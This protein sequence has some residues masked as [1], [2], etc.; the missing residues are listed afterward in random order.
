MRELDVL[1]MR[2]LE[3][4]FQLASASERAAF[5]QLL[6]LPDPDLFGYLVGRTLPVEA[7]ERDVIARIR[8]HQS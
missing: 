1:L 2:Y 3:Q 4:D 5:V 6:D 8:R 7:T